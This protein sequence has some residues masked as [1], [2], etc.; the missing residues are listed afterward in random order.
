MGALILIA[1]I[2]MIG[3]VYSQ[4]IAVNHSE[5]EDSLLY[6]CKIS[7]GCIEEQFDKDHLLFNFTGFLFYRAWRALGYDRCVEYPIVTL[8]IIFSLFNLLILFSIAT[9]LGFDFRLRLLALTAVAFSFGYWWYTVECDVYIVPVTFVLLCLRQLIYLCRT[10]FRMKTHVLLGVFSALAV[11][12]HRQHVILVFVILTSYLVIY[13]YRRR[14]ITPWR[15]VKGGLAYAA[16]CAAIVIAAYSAVFYFIEG[17]AGDDQL[18][19]WAASN[20]VLSAGRLD[21]RAFLKAFLGVSRSII[22][23]HF[24]FSFPSVTVLLEKKLSN[25]LLCEEIFLVQNFKPWKSIFLLV[26]TLASAFLAFNVAVA[27]IRSGV[28]GSVFSNRSYATIRRVFL[29]IFLVFLLVY[30]LF[31][32]WWEPQNIEFWIPVIP[33]LVLFICTVLSHVP[34]GKRIN[35][36]L[37]I[38][39]ILMFTVNLF[40]SVL[41]Q[42]CRELDYWYNFNS[43]LIEN[44]GEGDLVLSGSGQVSNSYVEYYSGAKTFCDTYQSERV[45]RSRLKQAVDSYEPERI[46][47]SST[48]FSPI[49]QFFRRRSLRNRISEDFFRN[50]RD[51]LEIYHTDSFQTIYVLDDKGYVASL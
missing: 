36:K 5:S 14:E 30:S 15:L 43:W 23:C 12:Y 28:I 27:S 51:H 40:G 4:T 18:I 47:V 25:Y 39:C 26:C 33:V 20:R 38:I 3:A 1:L 6:I 24:L 46:L 48:F 13:L 8:N 41:P 42:T 17:A 37:L 45:L 29:P 11:L 31:T 35:T 32:I 21:L 34:S 19:R 10:S 2:V 16:V 7:K 9:Q 44:C 50:L 49:E 22:G